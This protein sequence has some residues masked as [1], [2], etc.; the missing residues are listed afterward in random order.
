MKT[1]F[2][3]GA[4]LSALLFAT[5]ALAQNTPGDQAE[6]INLLKAQAE[7]IAA[8][9][10]RLDKI[11]SARP[12]TP[13]ASASAAAPTQQQAAPK[14][15]V[16]VANDETVADSFAPQ[17][18]AADLADQTVAQARALENVSNV[19]TEWRGGLPIFRSADGKFLFKMRGRIINHASS[20]FGSNYDTRNI[21]TTGARALRIGIEGA[22][23]PHFF[24][25][26]E[27]DFADNTSDVGTM[28]VG[29]RNDIGKVSYDVRFGNMF[30]DRGFEGSGGSDAPP[31]L[32]RNVVG[33]S[34]IPQRGFYG[35]ALMSRLFWNTG[36]A[37]ITLSGDS[38]DATQA[39]NDS[40][41]VM[42]RAHWNP[43]KTGRSLVHVGLWGFD[44]A[45]SSRGPGTLTRNTVIGGRF[46]GNLR[47]QTGTLVGGTG[48]T[49]YGA[50]LGGY[51]GPF[52]VMG[53]AGKRV[54]HLN[55]GRPDFESKAWSLST[56][57]FVTGDLPPY[58]PR[59]GTFAQPR[60]LRPVFDGGP[61]AIEILARY[62]NLEYSGIPNATKG[63]AATIGTNWYLDS[64]IRVQ[65][66]LI[67]W[68]TNN[69]TGSFTGKD[70]GETI[71]AGFGITF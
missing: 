29:W 71:S 34:I 20:T 39:T 59:L 47:V 51:A 60:V 1:K 43:Y 61:G 49:G 14:R 17:L 27:N 30:N 52:W 35:I 63:E 6:L 22:V 3:A 67:H 21:T 41:T 44:E 69:R 50:E 15:R 36:H 48:T 64:I 24:Y 10:A 4:A 62:E 55:A 65:L 11:E 40:R 12:V 13:A 26:F 19:N 18:A 33:T 53:E 57:F 5:P 31:F 28:F 54:A 42:A 32:E 46:N 38:V 25:Q 58:N 70:S 45:L 16:S 2:L 66:N 7:E 9:R 8:L 23:G 56:G 68:K 37:S